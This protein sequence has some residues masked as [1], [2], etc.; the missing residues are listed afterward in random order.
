[1]TLLLIVFI[2]AVKKAEFGLHISPI[3][4]LPILK[5]LMEQFHWPKGV[6][7]YLLAKA[8]IIVRWLFKDLNEY[9]LG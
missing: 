6:T 9:K 3:V 1:L 5:D 8:I 2:L 4:S 7:L